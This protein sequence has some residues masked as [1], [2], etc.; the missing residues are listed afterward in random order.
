MKSFYEAARAAAASIDAT[1]P[2]TLAELTELRHRAS[3]RHCLCCTAASSERVPG[4]L[5]S[6]PVERKTP[7][8]R[9]AYRIKHERRAQRKQKLASRSARAAPAAGVP[10]PQ[11]EGDRHP[12]QYTDGAAWTEL[13]TVARYLSEDRH[14]DA[15]I[16]LWRAGTTLTPL[17][18]LEAVSSCRSTGLH[19]AADAVL[20]GASQRADKQAVLNI[21]AA[22]HHAG[23]HEDVGYLLAASA[24]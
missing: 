14:R 16:L 8:Y 12:A 10:V 11:H 19:E 24:Q 17:Q 23:R 15:A 9:T 1:L 22:F 3:A 2:F 21:T 4:T 20:T 6:P 7:A 13:E 18:L 5:D